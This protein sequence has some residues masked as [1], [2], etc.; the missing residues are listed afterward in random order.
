MNIFYISDCPKYAA[1][2]Q[3]DKHVVKMC[4]ETAQMLCTA[5]RRWEDPLSEELSTKLYKNAHVHHP[6]TIWVGDS[7]QQ[8][9]WTYHHFMALL[10]EYTYRYGKVHA[11]A[12]LLK[13]LDKIP[14]MMP[15]IKITPPPQCMPDAFK[16][17]DCVEAYRRY[18]I[19][20]AETA[21][22]MRWTERDVPE[23]FDSKLIDF[24][25]EEKDT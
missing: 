21:F 18:Y 20:K 24:Y 1:Q 2:W 3:C 11:S 25:F 23:W 19:H 22:E 17:S 5:Y 6:M 12:R 4:L 16:G 13:P 14:E 9:A 15:N 10:N 7:T 8:Y